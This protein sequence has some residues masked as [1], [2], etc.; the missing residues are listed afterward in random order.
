LQK[1]ICENISLLKIKQE[2][3]S[4][5]NRDTKRLFEIARRANTLLKVVR[6][7]PP[8]KFK[9]ITLH[10]LYTLSVPEFERFITKC[11]EEKNTEHLTGAQ[12]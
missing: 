8:P 10:W 7:F 9:L 12:N 1:K 2:M 3:R 11:K 5:L 4:I 6:D